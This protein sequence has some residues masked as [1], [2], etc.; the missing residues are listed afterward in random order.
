MTAVTPA[1]PVAPAASVAAAP[2]TAPAVPAAADVPAVADAPAVAAEEP[3]A[4]EGPPLVEDPAAAYGD[5]AGLGEQAEPV[6][7]GA[8]RSVM[9]HHAKGVAVITAGLDVPVGFCA[10]SLSSVS[11]DPPLVSFTVGREASARSTV[12]R[13][14]HVVVHL[15]A[16]DQEELAR[17]FARSGA[18]RFG[19]ATRWHR[20]ALGLPVLDG[21]L[22]WLAVALVRVV[23]AG[24]HALVIG[25]VV[26]TG[27]GADAGPGGGP[28]AGHAPRRAGRP[29]V[30]HDGVFGGF[31]PLEADT[32]RAVG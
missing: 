24:D 3:E 18:P 25:C 32:G 10:T 6:D 29:L 14:R 21:V 11:L 9:R 23:P 27:P 5:A 31:V 17:R 26:A 20:G 22:A 19:P 8:F 16:E 7:A 30:H 12:E 15:L 28:G 13:A 4:M 1:A 2:V